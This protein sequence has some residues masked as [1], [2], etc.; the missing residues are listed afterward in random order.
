MDFVYRVSLTRVFLSP[1]PRAR[2]VRQLTANMSRFPQKQER[3]QERLRQKPHGCTFQ[4][5]RVVRFFNHSCVF[6]VLD[7]WLM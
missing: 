4:P 6:I 5:Q 2:R 7:A 1:A 3:K